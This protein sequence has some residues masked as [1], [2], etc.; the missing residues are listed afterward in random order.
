MCF[1][2]HT[3]LLNRRV[4]RAVHWFFRSVVRSRC[5]VSA[6]VLR[7]QPVFEFETGRWRGG[8]GMRATARGVDIACG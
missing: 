8:V 1:V 3:H 6:V 2:V 7:V 5:R 4:C